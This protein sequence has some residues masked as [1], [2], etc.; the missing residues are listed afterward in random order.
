LRRIPI[1]LIVLTLVAL[2]LAACGG[3]TSST[4]AD[5]DA[6]A[7]ATAPA[8]TGPA[9]QTIQISAPA[10][11][12]LAFDQK[13]LKTNAGTVALDF[14]NPASVEHNL[15]VRS[16]SGDDLGCSADI[17]E[18]STTLTVD[19]QPGKYVV[20]CG[21]PGHEEGGMTTPLVVS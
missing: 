21:E 11:G 12:S 18:S 9:D 20:Y 15:C 16:V 4:T 7:D 8:A 6:D 10:D 14:E 2:G 19:L 13:S 5:A 17:S 1:A 3:D